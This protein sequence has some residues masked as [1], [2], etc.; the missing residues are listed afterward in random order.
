MTVLEGSKIWP[1]SL[2]AWI[3]DVTPLSQARKK[4]SLEVRRGICE[5]VG[6]VLKKFEVTKAVMKLKVASSGTQE[7][8]YIQNKKAENDYYRLVEYEFVVELVVVVLTD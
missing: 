8:N 5:T 7:G 2:L 3:R 4:S 1:I 6:K